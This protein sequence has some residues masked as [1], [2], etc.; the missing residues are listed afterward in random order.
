MLGGPANI[1]DFSYYFAKLRLT[2]S[3]RATDDDTGLLAPP[4]AVLGLI[5]DTT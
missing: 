5:E 3:D 2:L 4:P 1:R